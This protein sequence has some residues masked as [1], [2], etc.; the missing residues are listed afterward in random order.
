[1][2]ISAWVVEEEKDHDWSFTD[3]STKFKMKV[4]RLYREIT[5]TQH[6]HIFLSFC[7]KVRT[8]RMAENSVRVVTVHDEA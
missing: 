2:Q 7:A 6:T 3:Q 1:M 4:S 5:N 8:L